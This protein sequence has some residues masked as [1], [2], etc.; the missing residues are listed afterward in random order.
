MDIKSTDFKKFMDQIMS[1]DFILDLTM[2]DRPKI[3]LGHVFTSHKGEISWFV[4]VLPSETQE[5]FSFRKGLG[6][7]PFNP[8]EMRDV[9]P[10]GSHFIQM[11]VTDYVPNSLLYH[12][13]KNGKLNMGVKAEDSERLKSVSSPK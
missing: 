12:A 7:T 4:V 11:Y 5:K 2:T 1:K 3:A 9:T 8:P 10:T 13:F 6:H